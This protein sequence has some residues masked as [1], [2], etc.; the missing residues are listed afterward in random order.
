MP[1]HKKTYLCAIASKYEP[2]TDMQERH[3][4]RK[5]YF[6][7]LAETSEK[8]YIPYLT[9]F[10]PLDASTRVLEIG[11]GEGGNL[12]PFARLGCQVIG[13]DISPSRIRQASAFFSEEGLPG[14]F[15]NKDIFK[16]DELVGTFDLILI[17]D[18]IEHIPFKKELLQRVRLF[19]KP[20]GLA[21]FG[22]PVWQMPFGG[23]QQICQ[24]HF[25]AHAPFIH[26]LPAPLYKAL[27]RKCG[28]GDG[29]IDELLS[30]KQCRMTIGRFQR[31]AQHE[32]LRIT[33]RQLWFINPHYEIKFGLRPRKLVNILRYTP[34]VRN[35][36]SSSAWY[37]VQRA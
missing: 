8:Y 6:D 3:K 12:K 17:H 10:M 35:F 31:L 22:F 37:I 2:S 5:Q 16:A 1:L 27:L 19:L 15:I 13:V 29:N 4:D 9:R 32:R 30:I 33:D 28:E 23:H 18:V 14:T 24:S 7:E 20:H 26:L 25:C 34:Y 36:L 21:F 11:C